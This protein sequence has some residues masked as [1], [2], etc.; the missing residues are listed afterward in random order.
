M[1]IEALGWETWMIQRKAEE[2]DSA[3]QVEKKCSGRKA[4]PT[5]NGYNNLWRREFPTAKSPQRLSDMKRSCMLI[6]R[7]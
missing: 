1:L 5:D 3:E 2:E 4:E 6:G 7:S